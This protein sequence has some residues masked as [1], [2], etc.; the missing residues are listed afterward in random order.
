MKS[1][2]GRDILIE[3]EISNYLDTHFYNKVVD[4]FKRYQ[5]EL[6]QNKGIDVHFEWPSLGKILVDEKSNSSAKYIN[7]FIPTFA[8]EIKNTSSGNTGWLIDNKK[9]TEYYLLIY[10]WANNAES[11]PIGINK[12][13]C[14]L[15]NRKAIRD[16]L[17]SNG[18]TDKE[19]I[20]ECYKAEKNNTGGKISSPNQNFYFYYTLWLAEKPFNVIIRRNVLSELSVAEFEID[21]GVINKLSGF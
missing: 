3:K 6:D 18:Y 12:L 10:V 20:K 16:Y 14:I 1:Q 17:S 7:Q 9:L 21:N 8:F 19:L 15:V 11:I 4:G 5:S 2:F 13:H